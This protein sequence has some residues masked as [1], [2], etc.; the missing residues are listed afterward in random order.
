MDDRQ[1]D[2]SQKAQEELDW[3]AAHPQAIRMRFGDRTNPFYRYG[4]A[5][6]VSREIR[7]WYREKRIEALTEQRITGVIHN[8]PY[9]K[10]V[11]AFLESIFGQAFDM[12]S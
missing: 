6:A 8:G 7:I 1:K 3:L 11:Y 10:E 12:K 5:P 9:K 2:I 4:H